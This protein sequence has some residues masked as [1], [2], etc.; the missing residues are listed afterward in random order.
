MP[1]DLNRT[2]E[3]ESFVAEHGERLLRAAI[4]LAGSREAGEDLLQ[5]ALERVLRRWRDVRQNPDS[6][7]RQT[8]VHLAADG[9]RRRAVWRGKAGILRASGPVY[10]ADGTAAV[11]S[12]DE[13]IGLLRQLPVRQRTAIVLRYLEDLTET[14]AAEL[15]GC[16]V[17]TV[18]SATSR[19]LDRLRELSRTGPPARNAS[20]RGAS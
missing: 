16:S 11:D 7:T 18:K 17:G 8:L 4:F 2:A 12:R 6:Y 9:W 14:E 19:G 3:L 13:V 15:M 5:A 10:Q 1:G 20:S